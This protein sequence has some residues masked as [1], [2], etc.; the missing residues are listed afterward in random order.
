MSAVL[1]TAVDDREPP[2]SLA[3]LIN[4]ECQLAADREL[5]RQTVRERDERVAGEVLAHAT[6]LA[7]PSRREVLRRWLAA[8]CDDRGT[9]GPG[10]RVQAVYRLLAVGLAAF[11][12]VS[13]AGTAAA[14]LHYDGTQPVNIVHFLA[15]FVGL[16]LPLIALSLVNMLPRRWRSFVPGFGP[17]HELL[18]HLGYRQ[19]GLERWLS[20]LHG[21]GGRVAV[22]LAR[23]RSWGTIYADVERWTLLGL[24]QRVAVF[25]NLGALAC[26]VYLIA[27]TDLAFAWSTT[28]SLST[29]AMTRLLRAL[30]LPWWWLSAAVPSAELVEA[31]RYY[32]QSGVYDPVLLK[33]WWAY[34][35]AALLAYG[36]VPRLVLFT[37]TTRR[38]Y[39]A[40]RDLTL[41]HGELEAVYERMV[42]AVSGWSSDPAGP[43]GDAFARAEVGAS[44]AELPAAGTVSSCTVLCWGDVPL[45]GDEP[46]ALVEQRFGWRTGVVHGAG[47]K[48][49]AGQHSMLESLASG[50][51]REPVVVVAEAWEAPGKAVR[52]FLR[53]VRRAVGTKRPIVVCL[54]AGERGAWSTPSAEDRGLWE[55]A[56]ALLADPYLRVEAMVA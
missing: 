14:L 33:D 29:E 49:T 47:G 41:D 34:L 54:L 51:A 39:T 27:V 53:D 1:L 32:R 11:G 22:S 16:Q 50:G 35:I 31:S 40:R 43:G 30:A 8:V 36:L 42:R 21:D 3:E 46:G 12:L 15:V 55:Q 10:E 24:T 7:A 38:A 28:L 20:R 45:S 2:L 13:G 6:G 44:A 5:D 56:A 23:V 9:P 52:R 37:V 18:R 48:D 19:A 26:C 17:L 25:F 4:L